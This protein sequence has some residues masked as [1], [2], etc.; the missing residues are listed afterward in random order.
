MKQAI[1]YNRTRCTSNFK[2]R[3]KCSSSFNMPSNTILRRFALKNNENSVAH[4]TTRLH[5]LLQWRIR[6]ISNCNVAFR[7]AT[8]PPPSKRLCRFHILANIVCWK[9]LGALISTNPRFLPLIF[10]DIVIYRHFAHAKAILAE[11][12]HFS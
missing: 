6:Y 2:N 9:F 5:L 11:N 12:F 3:G 4:R 8:N 1:P 10:P 7:I